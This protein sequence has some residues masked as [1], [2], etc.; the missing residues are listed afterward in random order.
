[1]LDPLTGTSR[2]ASRWMGYTDAAGVFQPVTMD[3]VVRYVQWVLK[4]SRWQTDPN[5]VYVAGYS[6]GGGGAMHI[7][8]LFPHVFAAGVA[9]AGWI[10]I[11]AWNPGPDWTDC[12]PG[13]RWRTSTGPLCTQMFDQVYLTQNTG[14]DLPPLMLAF[15]SNDTVVKATRYP[16]LMTMLET[17]RQGYVAVWRQDNHQFVLVENDPQ[18]RYR[19]N[20]P[21]V[22][23]SGGG[24]SMT[25]VDGFTAD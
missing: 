25:A 8:T 9:S 24:S 3:R 23:F 7:A 1:M 15:N 14:G 13:V 22:V 4:D 17:M 18:L 16:E 10:D 20:S 12:K 6:M 19:L 2:P 21:F 11:A 5:R